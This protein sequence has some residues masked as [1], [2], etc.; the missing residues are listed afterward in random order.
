MLADY[1]RR[2]DIMCKVETLKGAGDR[3]AKM[4]ASVQA[5]AYRKNRGRGGRQFRS[6]V[7]LSLYEWGAL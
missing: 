6:G 4:L 1:A 5:K 2:E 3:S 7:R